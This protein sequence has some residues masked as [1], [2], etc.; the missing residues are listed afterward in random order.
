MQI[1]L[2]QHFLGAGQHPLMLVLAVVRRGDRDQFDFG[3]LMLPDHA[4]G[5][6]PGRPGFGAKARRQ[7]GQPHRQFFLVEDGFADE[8]C[9][10]HFGGGDEP[11][12]FLFQ[13]I[14]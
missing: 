4:A 6:A 9:K 1:E 5:I 10:R 11:E 13:R 14:Q 8:I 12:P 7:R 3:E 2:P